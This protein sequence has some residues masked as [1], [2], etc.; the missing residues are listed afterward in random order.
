MEKSH[1]GRPSIC[2]SL[3]PLHSNGVGLRGTETPWSCATRQQMIHFDYCFMKKG[4]GDLLYVLIIKDDLSGYVWLKA[5]TE[6]DADTTAATLLDW[7][8]SFGVSRC[9]I[10]DQGSHFKNKLMERVSEALKAQHHFTL[11]YCPWSNRSVKAVCRELL[12]TIRALLSE[13][14]HPRTVI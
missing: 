14:Q 4:D 11:P 9:W 1:K 12:K 3:F 8:A 2:R 10:S 7:F 13:F 6:A 5:T